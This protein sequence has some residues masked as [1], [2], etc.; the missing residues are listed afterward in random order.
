MSV[1]SNKSAAASV[2]A[3]TDAEIRARFEALESRAPARTR[4]SKAVAVPALP[5][6]ETARAVRESGF[7]GEAR[8][9]LFLCL[10]EEAQAGRTGPHSDTDL[11]ALC[12]ARSAGLAVSA[13]FGVGRVRSDLRVIDNRLNFGF[14]PLIGYTSVLVGEKGQGLSITVA[15]VKPIAEKPKM[16]RKARKAKVAELPAPVADNVPDAD[17]VAQGE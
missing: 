4:A 1:K 2:P 11:V 15:P 8:R 13:T 17:A 3:L 12:K 5:E 7:T 16:V 9:T 10:V 6:S 14:F